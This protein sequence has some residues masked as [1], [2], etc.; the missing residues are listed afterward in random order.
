MDRLI[1]RSLQWRLGVRKG[2]SGRITD[3]QLS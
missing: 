3:T 2:A 1:N